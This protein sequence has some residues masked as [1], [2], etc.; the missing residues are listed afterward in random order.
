M[1]ARR[2]LVQQEQRAPRARAGQL[3][4]QLDALRFAPGKGAGRLTQG[5]VAESHVK[6]RH[7]L[8]RDRRHVAKKSRRLVNRH[9]EHIGDV[10]AL[11]GDL[12]RFTIVATSTTDLAF[13]VDVREEVHF[14]LDQSASL[15]IF[16]ASTFDV[17]TEPAGVVATHP[18]R[19]KLGK[20]FPNRSKRPGVSD[21]I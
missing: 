18:R 14:D 9:V 5:Q 20:E 6:Q 15:A 19:G 17:E 11:I 2:R 1:Q 10:L 21:G 8:V 3:G 4:R 13:H 7:E 16:A 12:E